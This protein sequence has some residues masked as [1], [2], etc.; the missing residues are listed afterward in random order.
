MIQRSREKPKSVPKLPR[1][2]LYGSEIA[3]ELVPVGLEYILSFLLS[4]AEKIIRDI[5][6]V[7]GWF[8]LNVILTSFSYNPSTHGYLNICYKVYMG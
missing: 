6:F 5:T 8:N 7:Y 3:Y 2:A 4:G 1:G